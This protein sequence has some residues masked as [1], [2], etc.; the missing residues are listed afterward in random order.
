MSDN[1]VL[2]LNART[3]PYGVLGQRHLGAG[4]RVAMRLWEDEPASEATP[5]SRRDY[6]SVGYVIKG[7]A[8]LDLEGQTIQLEP[9]DSWLAPSA[10]TGSSSPAPRSRRWR[11]QRRPVSQ[12]RNR[13]HDGL[14][15]VGPA[16]AP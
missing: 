5:P 16:A 3:A 14:S 15:G 9:G 4:R 13:C 6:E 10:A 8:E 2:K 7:A 11:R 12:G 1:M